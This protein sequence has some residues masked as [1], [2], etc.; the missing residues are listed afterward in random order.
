MPNIER[1]ENSGP[2]S[3]SYSQ[4]DSLKEEGETRRRHFPRARGRGTLG[5]IGERTIYKPAC[6]LHKHSPKGEVISTAG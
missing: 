1:L 3:Q 6:W 5:Q 4:T 2:G